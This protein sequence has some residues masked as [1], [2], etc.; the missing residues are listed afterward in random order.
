MRKRLKIKAIWDSDLENM[1]RSMGLLESLLEGRLHCGVCGRAIN[2]DNL[3]AL[4][5]YAGNI[6][7]ACDN[8]KCVQTVASWGKAP[9]DG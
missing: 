2:L 4:F 5:P 6:G 3:A 1:L 9:R 7:V 8:N